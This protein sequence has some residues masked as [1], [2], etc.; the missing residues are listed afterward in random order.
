M[1]SMVIKIQEKAEE[2]EKKHQ[3]EFNK[4]V[5][6][7]GE[8]INLIENKFIDIKK[9]IEDCNQKILNNSDNISINK[10]KIEEINGQIKDL[11]QKNKDLIFQIRNYYFPTSKLSNDLEK[12]KGIP[13]NMEIPKIKNEVIS[14]KKEMSPKKIIGKRRI[15]EKGV[16]L[17]NLDD[18]QTFT[19]IGRAHV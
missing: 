10:K 4:L 3:E 1:K 9:Y 16:L 18:I 2:N 14:P 7:K 5:N 12:V 15:I 17:T 8:F 11:Q 13:S 6:M 19:K